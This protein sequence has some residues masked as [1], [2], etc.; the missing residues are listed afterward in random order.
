MS[1]EFAQQP[2]SFFDLIFG[3]DG[4]RSPLQTRRNRGP[5]SK[6]RVTS[7]SADERGD[8]F[9]ATAAGHL[10]SF[11][12]CLF[13]RQLINSVLSLL[14]GDAIAGPGL[15]PMFLSL[16][17]LLLAGVIADAHAVKRENDRYI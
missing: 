17:L 7:P 16:V 4:F 12:L 9:D 1:N 8:L 13:A 11:A 14:A 3:E 5:P 15:W 10:R 2:D 6:A